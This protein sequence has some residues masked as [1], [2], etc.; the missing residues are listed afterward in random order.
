MDLL[1]LDSAFRHSA[2]LYRYEA[3]FFR[4]KK[5]DL[6]ILIKESKGIVIY[7]PKGD[8]IT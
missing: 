4:E 1:L 3:F 8:Y 2:A 7:P 6:D 5:H